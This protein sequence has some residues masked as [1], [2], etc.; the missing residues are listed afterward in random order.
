MLL[1]FPFT[2]IDGSLNTE[3][4]DDDDDD[5][6]RRQARLNVPISS[7]AWFTIALTVLKGLISLGKHYLCFLFE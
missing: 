2:L 7:A 1:I 3:D 6:G 5:V 4:D